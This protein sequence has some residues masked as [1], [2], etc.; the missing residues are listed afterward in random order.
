MSEISDIKNQ[1]ALACRILAMHGHADLTLGHISIRGPKDIIY[2]KRNDVG[3]DEVRENDIIGINMN[4]DIVEGKGETHL[5]TVLH[6][7]VYK[8]REDVFAVSH[9]HPLYSVALGATNG[10]LAMLN[11]DSFLFEDGLGNYK[12]IA[13]LITN[14]D[15]GKS[16]ADALGN[17]KAVI[18]KN[19]GLLAVGK[20]IPWLVY[21]NLT[22]ERAIKVQM[23]ANQL[24][25][26]TPLSNEIATKVSKE[27][28]RDSFISGYWKYLKRKLNRF[29]I[30]NGFS[31][32]LTQK[33][34]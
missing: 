20:T 2:I 6:V 32:N 10:T 24:G 27:K 17:R 28:Y 8:K 18:M 3:L 12:D 21:I 5:E 25:E 33:E 14:S 16:V 15:L 31:V 19:H 26:L 9:T 22:L 29:E 11:H 34:N 4:G 7:E 23:M 13:G 30:G 1:V